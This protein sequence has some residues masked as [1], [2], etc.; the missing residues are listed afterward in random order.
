MHGMLNVL[1]NSPE[2]LKGPIA[3]RKNKAILCD[4][5]MDILKLGITSNIPN[6]TLPHLRVR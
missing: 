1:L 6:K 3:I 4:N 5:P 2:L